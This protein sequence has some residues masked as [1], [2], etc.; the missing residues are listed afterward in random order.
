M[1]ITTFGHKRTTVYLPSD[2]Y[3][4]KYTWLEKLLVKLKWAFHPTLETEEY[5]VIHFDEKDFV[6]RLLAEYYNHRYMDRKISQVYIGVEQFDEL[7]YNKNSF[8]IIQ[9]IKFQINGA[10]SNGYQMFGLTVTILPYM[11]G[12]LFV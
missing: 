2:D 5:Q 1:K 4:F 9:P 6:K 3:K 11:D 12:V 10:I 8:D 7:I